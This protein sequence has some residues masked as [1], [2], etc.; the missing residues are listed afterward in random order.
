MQLKL[1]LNPYM[2]PYIRFQVLN[3]LFIYLRRSFPLSHRRYVTW[4]LTLEQVL[5]FVPFPAA[6]NVTLII[7]K[8]APLICLSVLNQCL[9]H[10]AFHLLVHQNIHGRPYVIQYHQA[11]QLTESLSLFV[12]IHV[13]RFALSVY[14]LL[15]RVAFPQCLL[16]WRVVFQFLFKI[17]VKINDDF[18]YR[19]GFM[20]F[21]PT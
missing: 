2:L 11:S 1:L 14:V 3:N 16:G 17:Q 20:T 9:S 6:I 10:H 21:A 4:S 15:I 19:V 18:R 7:H 8:L 5:C 13:I 12:C